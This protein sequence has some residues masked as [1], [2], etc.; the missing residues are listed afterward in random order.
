LLEL[1]FKS[2]RDASNLQKCAND[3]GF[4]SSFHETVFQ[5]QQHY[6]ISI[7]KPYTNEERLQLIKS[8]CDFLLSEK[9]MDW[10]S[11]ILTGFYHYEDSDEIRQI[12]EIILEMRLGERPELTE[13]LE[14]WGERKFAEENVGILL[15]SKEPV[16]FDSWSKFRLKKLQDR[17]MEYVELAI[18]EYKMEQEYQMF[19]HML[20]EYL[21]TREQKK[22][23]IHLYSTPFG[24]R[25]F[26]EEF[27]ELDR[28]KLLACV[29]KRL[30]TN[31]P[32]YV[33]S[34]TIA[35]LLS[36]APEKIFVYSEHYEHN[37]IRTLQNIFEE[38][39][40]ILPLNYFPENF[41]Y[42]SLDAANE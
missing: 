33:D 11:S 10:A 34:Y 27:Q 16:S 39:V 29:D 5:N 25:F 8:I 21:S 1:L 9:C 3:S 20:R 42:T 36:L 28:V 31:H 4:I 22:T 2:K 14:D 32:L 41:L 26:D 17:Q 40:N 24:F 30:L 19:L 35:P 6:I 38:R 15:E 37:L 7:N 18:D 13:L 23:S 12:M